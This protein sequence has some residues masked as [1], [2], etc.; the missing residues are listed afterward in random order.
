LEK[1]QRT[2]LVGLIICSFLAF[3]GCDHRPE[4]IV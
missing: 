3:A 2:G 1:T 4:N